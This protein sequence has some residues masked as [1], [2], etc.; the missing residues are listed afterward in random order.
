MS[1]DFLSIE[2]VHRQLCEKLGF[3]PFRGTL[4]ITVEDPDAQRILKEKGTERIVHQTEGFCDGVLV[5]GLING[6]YEC[7]VIIPLVENY[8]ERL[9]EVVAPVHLK[10]ALCID[11]GDEVTLS[12]ETETSHE[13]HDKR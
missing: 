10:E 5:K 2:W 3:V 7:G 13:D 9:L 6:K 11:E 8:D 4:N 12:L 1:G